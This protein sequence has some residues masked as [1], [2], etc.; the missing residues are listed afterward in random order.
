M[1]IIIIII[2][3]LIIKIIIVKT[4]KTENSFGATSPTK[5]P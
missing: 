5:V 4:L 3:M 2:I 1:I